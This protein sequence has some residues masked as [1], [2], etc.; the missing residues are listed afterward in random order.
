MRMIWTEMVCTFTCGNRTASSSWGLQ[1][2]QNLTLYLYECDEG[3]FFFRSRLSNNVDFY[4]VDLKAFNLPAALVYGQFFVLRRLCWLLTIGEFRFGR[5]IR[6][7]N[8]W[9][10]RRR[11]L[12]KIRFISFVRS[13]NRSWEEASH[14]QL[15]QL[16]ACHEPPARRATFVKHSNSVFAVQELEVHEYTVKLRHSSCFQWSEVMVQLI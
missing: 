12:A 8:F 14:F 11:H 1:L 2:S 9:T 6:S 3:R 4:P 10:S 7:E 13:S 16:L 5:R 15:R